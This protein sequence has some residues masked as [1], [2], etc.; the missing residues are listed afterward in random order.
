[1]TERLYFIDAY[2]RGFT[3]HVTAAKELPVASADPP[4]RRSAVALDRTAFYPE[5]GGQPSDRG[6]LNEVRVIDV[7]SDDAGTVWHTLDGTLDDDM[8]KGEVD[9][10]RRFDHMQQHHG[11]HLLSAAFEE[12]FGLKTVSFHLGPESATIDLAGDA[13]ETELFAAESRTNEVI[14]EDRPI[15][16]RFVTAEELAR[17]PLR[18]PPAV[19]GPIRV[20]SVPDFDYSACGGTH[21]KSTG[22]VGI[23]HIRRRERRGQDT[24]VEFVCGNRVLRDLRHRGGVLTRLGAV[25]T[26]GI[27]DLEAAV[28][29]LRVDHEDA[30]KR[31]ATTAG[32]LLQFEAVSL[33]DAAAGRP[34]GVVR[35][36]LTLDEA[37][38]LARL[39]AERGVTAI[40]GVAG[41]KAQVVITRPPS[42]SGPDCGKVLREALAKF[43]GKGGGQPQSAQG[44][45]PDAS[46]LAD[47]IAAMAESI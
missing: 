35:D 37:R 2:L 27:D 30:R 41:Q 18:K 28:D 6:L 22:A 7:Q 16:A 31:L 26:A 32:K 38:L 42:A 43:G 39:V 24:R 15:E 45:I 46:R 21:P 8:V 14:W 33:A 47:V 9:W 29:R 20:V 11:Q 34:V 12:L 1:M 17:L 4:L 5:G 36:D 3:A 13:G 10:P 19:S 25:F 40:V 23:L 44:G